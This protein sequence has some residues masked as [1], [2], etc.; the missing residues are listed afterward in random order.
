M[1]WDARL[2]IVQ[3]SYRQRAMKRQTV[4]GQNILTFRRI[5]YVKKGWGLLCGGRQQR[6]R[7]PSNV[8]CDGRQQCC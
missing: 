3:S 6:V 8:W 2:Q 4:Y 7:R 1:L 5:V